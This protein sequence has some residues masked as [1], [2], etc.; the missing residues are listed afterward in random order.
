MQKTSLS[1]GALARAAGVGVETVRFYERKG[2]LQEPPRL[3]S[4]YRAYPPATVERLRF[5]RRAKE[6]GFTLN[7]IAELLDLEV[8][9]H[10]TCSDMKARLQTKIA[11][12][13]ARIQSLK[14]IRAALRELSER[15]DGESPVSECAF[16]Q[17]LHRENLP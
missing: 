4:G 14:A 8:A 9:P 15:C 2:L 12:V 17:T 7:E 3:D 10:T 5:I 6:L 13:E 11:D 16:L 1:I